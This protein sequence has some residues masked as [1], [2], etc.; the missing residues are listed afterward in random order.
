MLIFKTANTLFKNV[1]ALLPNVAL[2][3]TRSALT[4]GLKTV[5]PFVMLEP[6]P[7]SFAN[8]PFAPEKADRGVG[9]RAEDGKIR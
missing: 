5:L 1:F 9:E 8:V 6:F 4:N 3:S 7:N 2:L